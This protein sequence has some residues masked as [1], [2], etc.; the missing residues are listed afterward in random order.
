LSDVSLSATLFFPLAVDTMKFA[1]ATV[2][3]LV[4]ATC[5]EGL[6]VNNIFRFGKKSMPAA[7][8]VSPAPASKLVSKKY[9]LDISEIFDGNKKFVADKLAENPAYF[10]TLGIVHSPKY[11]YIGKHQESN[12]PVRKNP[13]VYIGGRACYCLT[14]F[15]A[16]SFPQF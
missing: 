9:D 14:L 11:L 6:H 2:A 10:D 3:L 16:L 7:A 4:L 5:V 8:P 1:S 15:M 12:A 13:I